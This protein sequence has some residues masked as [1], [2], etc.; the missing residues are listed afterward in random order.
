MKRVR[1]LVK[2]FLTL[3]NLLSPLFVFCF[4]VVFFAITYNFTTCK[5]TQK[6]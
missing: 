5:C 6:I 1:S 3:L 2:K 4:A